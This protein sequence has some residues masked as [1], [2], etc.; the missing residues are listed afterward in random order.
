MLF[1]LMIPPLT[2]SVRFVEVE[3]LRSPWQRLV[4]SPSAM[5]CVLKW[6]ARFLLADFKSFSVAALCRPAL[7]IPLCFL[8][9]ASK[10]HLAFLSDAQLLP[11]SPGSFPQAWLWK[12]MLSLDSH[13][14]NS[15]LWDPRGKKYKSLFYFKDCTAKTAGTS[16]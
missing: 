13:L 15:F 10:C 4:Y 1:R 14:Y 6:E 3:K 5:M 2:F 11:S 12:E 16:T 9:Q 8:P 7:Y